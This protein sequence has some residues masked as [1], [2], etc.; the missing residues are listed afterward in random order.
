MKDLTPQEKKALSYEKDRRNTYG[1]NDKASRNSIPKRKA[2]VNRAYRKGISDALKVVPGPIDLERAEEVEQIARSA[3]R[4]DWRKSP[5]RPL[6]EVVKQNLESRVGHAGRGKSALKAVREFVE[7]VEIESEQI[8]TDKWVARAKEYPWIAVNGASK[9][10]VVEKLKHLLTVAKRNE[11]GDGISRVQIDGE[12]VM[13][14]LS[15]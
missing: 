2:E 12:F 4:N 11:L 9:V 7:N 10:R 6:G 8:G 3:K 1:Q 14:T 5:D 13:P 15:K